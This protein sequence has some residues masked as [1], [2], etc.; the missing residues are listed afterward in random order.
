MVKQRHTR[1]T[2]NRHNKKDLLKFARDNG[3][4]V[5]TTMTKK[6]LVDM[7]FR[8][9]A[10]RDKV[11]LKEKR[12]LTEKQKANLKKFGYKTRDRVLEESAKI[13]KPIPVAAPSK[14]VKSAV[15]I[16]PKASNK[17]QP[18]PASLKQNPA[19]TNIGKQIAAKTKTQNPPQKAVIPKTLNIKE[20]ITDFK[21]GEKK[22][23]KEV[24]TLLT[25]KDRR[26]RDKPSFSAHKLKQQLGGTQFDA[27]PSALDSHSRRLWKNR[28]LNARMKRTQ[29]KEMLISTSKS[30]DTFDRAIFDRLTRKNKKEMGI[31][32]AHS[33][34]NADRKF[35]ATLDELDS[36]IK[37]IDRTT[38]AVDKTAEMIKL[39]GLLNSGAIT[40]EEFKV[41][42]DRLKLAKDTSG[43]RQDI[44]NWRDTKIEQLDRQLRA[45]RINQEE[46]DKKKDIIQRQFINK[47]NDLEGKVEKKKAQ[48]INNEN[49]N[50]EMRRRLQVE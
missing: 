28:S 17:N 8:N 37:A 40:Q 5:K 3:L 14:P 48:P 24:N 16:D 6:I 19:K 30:T 27:K 23:T 15:K 35:D 2:I 32:V 12:K 13:S 46:Y 33:K 42:I 7:I 1:K 22:E 34:R 43:D 20:P 47:I 11:P 9:K 4:K 26:Y 38:S 41:R 49:N 50:G 44:N 25:K 39:V 10:L 45:G 21:T 29:L 36:E 18:A 31:A